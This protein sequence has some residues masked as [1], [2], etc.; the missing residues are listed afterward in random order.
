MKLQTAIKTSLITLAIVISG[1][2]AFSASNEVVKSEAYT[3]GDAA[4]YY[5]DISSTAEG[6]TLLSS[7]Q[8]LNSARKKSNVGYDAMGTSASGQFKYTDY[9]PTTVKYDGNNQPYGTK[10]L[11]F[12]SGTPTTSFN[13]EHT[14]PDSH[15]GNS[16]EGDIHMTR[17][18][19]S[20]ENGS[21]GNSFYVE[22]KKSQSEGWDP[23]METWGDE[24]YRGDA[25]RITFYGVVANS[26]LSLLDVDSHSTSKKNR[27]NKMGKLSDILKW[28]LEYPVSQREKNRNEGAEYLQGNRNPFIDHPEYACRIWGNYNEATKA[29]CAGQKTKTVTKLEVTSAGSAYSVKERE[30]LQLT[31]KATVKDDEGSESVIDVT[32]SATYTTTVSSKDYSQYISVSSTGLITGLKAVSYCAVGVSYEGKSTAFSPLEVTEN[33]EPD[34]PVVVS[35]SIIF[36]TNDTLDALTTETAILNY[37]K[38]GSGNISS[39]TTIKSLY[40]GPYGIKMG[41]SSSI[42]QLEFSTSNVLKAKTIASITI[43]CEQYSSDTGTLNISINGDTTPIASVTPNNKSETITLSEPKSITSIKIVTSQK[44]AYLSA[45]KFNEKTST[46]TAEEYASSFL[47]K[48]TCSGTGSTTFAKSVWATVKNEFN[49]LETTEQAKLINASANENGTTIEQCVARYDYLINKYGKNT[50]EDFI[51]RHESLVQKLSNLHELSNGKVPLIIVGTIIA[52][53]SFTAIII[54]IRRKKEHN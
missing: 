11:G 52:V 35:N 36:N 40:K 30:T 34:P 48:I 46:T 41:S 47:S 12:Y 44:R 6:T 19:L 51:G 5:K 16:I 14:W 10:V 15:G 43:D 33:E 3:N 23:A 54:A 9:D 42:G 7:L 24:T 22:G 50:Y 13:R 20:D 2:G 26:N 45:I 39:V 31:V 38:E 4:T 17:P 1:V 29:V 32:S 28:N 8:S 18:T 53:L 37:V 27:D 25:A 49:G 21:R